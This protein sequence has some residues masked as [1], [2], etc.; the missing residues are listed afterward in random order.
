[1][2]FQQQPTQVFRAPAQLDKG[3]EEIH[4]LYSICSIADQTEKLKRLDSLHEDWFTSDAT[5]AIYKRMRA[6]RSQTGEVPTFVSLA[7]DTSLPPAS[8]EI[9]R[10]LQQSGANYNMN[11]A[12]WSAFTDMLRNNFTLLQYWKMHCDMASR[13][14]ELNPS[15]L[16][17][18]GSIVASYQETISKQVARRKKPVRMGAGAT[19]NQELLNKVLNPNRDEDRIK[20]GFREFDTRTGGLLRGNVMLIMSKF[21]G[22]KS[23]LAL[24]AGVNMAKNG[25]HGAYISF[26]LGD[27]ELFERFLTNISGVDGN[28]IRLGG[29]H[30]SEGDRSRIQSQYASFNEGE[31]SLTLICPNTIS[32][33]G[34]DINDTLHIIEGC[35][36]DFVIFDY[37]GL[38]QYHKLEGISSSREDQIL[39]D[40]ARKI[41]IHAESHAYAAL[42]LHQMTD[43]GKIANARAIGAHVDFIWKWE[44]KEEDRDRGWVTVTQDKAR[45]A[46][47]YDMIFT[48]AFNFMQMQNVREPP[49][50]DFGQSQGPHSH[51]QGPTRPSPLT[52]DITNF[53]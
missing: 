32:S 17:E 39:S 11:T 3:R 10:I 49:T 1:M 45:S 53:H 46:P 2:P 12:D 20:M 26:E 25:Y 30:L 50:V 41:K 15:L 13:L 18:I 21:G 22:G 51:Q 42:V 38:I 44:V 36:Y 35:G 33:G 8:Q 4:A 40:M 9:A 24:T 14:R 16:G 23:A 43:E 5:R 27:E 7:E 47:V 6:S 31:G 29:E 34:W 48:L 28:N 52:M 19:D 37:L